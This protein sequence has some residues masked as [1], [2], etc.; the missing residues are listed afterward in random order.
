ML[1]VSFAVSTNQHIPLHSNV[2]F[3]SKRPIQ[4]G[5]HFI[6]YHPSVSKFLIIGPNT[7]SKLITAICGTLF[8]EEDVTAKSFAE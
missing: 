7:N 1:Y 4:G 8:F 5:D 2:Y 6:K 3:R